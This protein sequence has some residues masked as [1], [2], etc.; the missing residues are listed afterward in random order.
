MFEFIKKYFKKHMTEIHLDKVKVY[1]DGQRLLPIHEINLE[2]INKP[3][4]GPF[5]K[6]KQDITLKIKTKNK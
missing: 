4:L 5:L 6:F 1:L 3:S 2:I